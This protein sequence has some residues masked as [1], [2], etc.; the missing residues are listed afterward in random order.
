MITES[1]LYSFA[2]IMWE[3][4]TGKI[5]WS[6]K[7]IPVQIVMAVG[8]EKKRLPVPTSMPR[9]MKVML[10]DCWRHD[11]RLRPSFKE[12]LSKLQIVSK[13]NPQT[14]SAADEITDDAIGIGPTEEVAVPS[15]SSSSLPS[16]NDSM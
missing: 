2:V 15:S 1:D 3:S 16:R 10:R 14:P 13:K 11:P 5:P 6:E 7:Q 8:I 4:F 12:L 9:G